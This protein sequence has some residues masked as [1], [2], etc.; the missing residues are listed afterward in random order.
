MSNPFSTAE[1]L[2]SS[3]NYPEFSFEK[4][5]FV[6]HPFRGNQ[7]KNFSSARDAVNKM[8]GTARP[9]DQAGAQKY[10]GDGA[11]AHASMVSALKEMKRAAPDNMKDTIERA[12][13]AHKEATAYHQR[14]KRIVEKHD[15]KS[16]KYTKAVGAGSPPTTLETN[17]VIRAVN[18]QG[19]AE[20][21]PRLRVA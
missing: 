9:A 17:E 16:S 11:Y 21:H 19:R 14:L 5:D 3:S 13:K 18:R 8:I 15:T 2:K 10:H 1:L 20:L 12:I 7:W 6:G 4:G